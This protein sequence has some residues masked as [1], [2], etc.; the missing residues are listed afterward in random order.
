MSIHLS[1][2]ELERRLPK[3]YLGDCDPRARTELIRLPT[4]D[5]LGGPF[6]TTGELTWSEYAGDGE[7][8]RANNLLRCSS[9]CDQSIDG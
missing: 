1:R 4:K 7:Q 8:T 5:S 2:N 3:P 6:A 9:I